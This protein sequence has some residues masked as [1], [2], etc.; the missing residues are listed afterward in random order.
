MFESPFF[1]A[2]FLTTVIKALGRQPWTVKAVAF[3]PETPSTV[4][5]RDGLHLLTI[6]TSFQKALLFLLKSFLK[7]SSKFASFFFF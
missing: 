5:G 1:P 4:H 7:T 3:E 2:L 6:F